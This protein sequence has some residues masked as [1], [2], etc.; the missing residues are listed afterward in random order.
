MRVHVQ[1]GVPSAPAAIGIHAAAFTLPEDLRDGRVS[2]GD[3]VVFAPGQAPAAPPG[4]RAVE[5]DP[6]AHADI[7]A[8]A[9]AALA[10]CVLVVGRA[11]TTPVPAALEAAFPAV[12]YVN[13][14][15]R[16]HA[17]PRGKYRC[18]ASD[19]MSERLRLHATHHPEDC[20]VVAPT[21]YRNGVTNAALDRSLRARCHSSLRQ[22][23]PELQYSRLPQLKQQPVGW[24]T[25]GATVMQH[26]LF[27]DPAV[28]TLYM[29][30]F[31]HW[32]AD[33]TVTEPPRGMR[34]AFSGETGTHS[35]R[36]ERLAAQDATDTG[37]VVPLTAA[38]FA[39]TP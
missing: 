6:A 4:A 29:Y 33:G 38:H 12:C 31:S 15:L 2:R 9:A 28:D 24:L 25:T 7:D 3:I 8:A 30:G 17:G 23:D 37:R 22:V 19:C 21:H 32:A 16:T 20:L 35:T 14:D 26:F 39:G 18:C 27:A 1:D 11:V 10:G 13:C 34:D 36:F 5:F